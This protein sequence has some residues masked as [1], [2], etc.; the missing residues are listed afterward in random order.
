MIRAL[1]ALNRPLRDHV[2][3]VLTGARPEVD[4]PVRRADGLFIVLNHQHGIAQIAQTEQGL[5]Q[6]PVV[7]LMQADAGLVQDVE[8]PDEAGADLG[9][10]PNA[11]R[12]AAG[13][14]VRRAIQGE[15]LQT[16]GLQESQ[17]R[18]HFLQH[19]NRNGGLTRAELEVLEEPGGRLHRLAGGLVD[20]QTAHGHRQAFALEPRALARRTRAPRHVA[21]NL[22]T[23]IVGLGLLVAAAQIR[24]HAF[25]LEGVHPPLAAASHVLDGYGRRAAI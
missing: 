6:A 19:L 16:H 21:L 14:R 5:H 7:A 12:L 23:N 22:A 18:P 1:D 11:L 24:H 20:R 9:R 2:T 13:E 10:Q 8:H 25:K 17:T 15:V 3:A 4:H